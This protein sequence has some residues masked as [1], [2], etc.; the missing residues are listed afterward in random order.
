MSAWRNQ[1]LCT[2]AALLLVLLLVLVLVLVLVLLLLLDDPSSR[3]QIK[4]KSRS[5][6]GSERGIH[7]AVERR[8]IRW[9]I[10]VCLPLRYPMTALA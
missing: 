6:S 10:A 4:S 5:T 8:S 7:P 9:L 1:V 3:S 2:A